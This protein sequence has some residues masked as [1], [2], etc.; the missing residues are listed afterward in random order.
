[1]EE[2]AEGQC[3][4]KTYIMKEQLEKDEATRYLFQMPGHRFRVR[5]HHEKADEEPL[6]GWGLCS[7]IFL[8]SYALGSR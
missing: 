3:D 7:I 6:T 4:R 2:F 8:V 5:R 1:M